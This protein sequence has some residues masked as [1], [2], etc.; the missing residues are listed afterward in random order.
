MEIVLSVGILLLVVA[1]AVA[2]NVVGFAS[3]RR[4]GWLDKQTARRV[5]VHM[6]TDVTLEG[7][8]VVSARDGVVLRAAEVKGEPGRG[9]AELAGEIFVPRDQIV[10]MQ[11]PV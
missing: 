1:G 4:R 5:I 9:G 8:L 2:I 11:L 6:S 7:A 10:F 3:N